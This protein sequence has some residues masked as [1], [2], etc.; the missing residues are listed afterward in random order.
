MVIIIGDLES[1]VDKISR[2][3]IDEWHNYLIAFKEDKN[4][5]PIQLHQQFLFTRLKKYVASYTILK[6]LP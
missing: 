6:I 1:V 5:M 2:L 3:L 4:Q